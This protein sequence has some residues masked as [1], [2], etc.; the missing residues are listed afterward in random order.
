MDKQLNCRSISALNRDKI[1]LNEFNLLLSKKNE[2]SRSVKFY[3]ELLAISPKKLNNI[4]KFYC[5]KTAK[6]FIEDKII[7][8]SKKLLL[9]TA[10]T[11]KYI[12]YSMGFTEPTN[13]NKFFKKLTNI[14]PLQ[15]REQYDKGT[16]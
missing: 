11:V 7:S 5:G 15:F 3:A 1:L 6:E 12:S 13:F 2:F 14:T 9:D 10:D 16:F 4:T 8:D